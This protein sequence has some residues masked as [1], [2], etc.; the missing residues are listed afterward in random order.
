MK[1]S[2][3]KWLI[4]LIAALMALVII[5]GGC[6]KTSTAPTSAAPTPEK[7][8][9][10]MF[11]GS[12]GSTMNFKQELIGQTL[13]KKY[14]EWTVRVISGLTGASSWTMMYNKNLE[15]CTESIN[16]LIDG[17]TKGTFAGIKVPQ[18][19]A[20]FLYATDVYVFH[21]TLRSE[22][23]VNSMEDFINQKKPLKLVI[24]RPGT[25]PYSLVGLALEAGYGVT[26]KDLEAWGCKLIPGSGT[27]AA[28]QI[29]D[30]VVDGW[31]TCGGIPQITLEE[32]ATKVSLKVITIDNPAV[33][34]KLTAAGMAPAVIKAGGYSFVKKHMHCVGSPHVSMVRADLS[35]DMATK[36]VKAVWEEREFLKNSYSGFQDSTD[37]A[38]VKTMNATYAKYLHPAVKKYFDA[39]GIK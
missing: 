17:S 18:M 14:P 35:D 37:P 21:L 31:L 6:A 39:Q 36:I 26:Y 12:V 1:S 32:I 28:N 22:V 2:M 25:A 4:P 15:I 7:I 10:R 38:F 33:V 16:E 30:G 9:M 20:K 13:R 24:G 23:Q 34:T 8:W 19:D 3:K 11:G 29:S 27:D 5:A